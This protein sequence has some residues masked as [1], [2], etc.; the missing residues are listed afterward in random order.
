VPRARSRW[1]LLSEAHG[2]EGKD[3]NLRY[4]RPYNAARCVALSH[5]ATSPKIKEPRPDEGAE[6]LCTQDQIGTVQMVE[7]VWL[8]KDK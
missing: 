2:G 7:G 3:S 5:S 1:H 8:L 4:G 6:A